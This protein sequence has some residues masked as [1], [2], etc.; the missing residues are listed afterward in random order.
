MRPPSNCWFSRWHWL[1]GRGH[2]KM[3]FHIEAAWRF[4][5]PIGA[6]LPPSLLSWALMGSMAGVME[7]QRSR[8]DYFG[9]HN[10][11]QLKNGSGVFINK[12][13]ELAKE[14]SA[15]VVVVRRWRMLTPGAKALAPICNST[16]VKPIYTSAKYIKKSWM[17]GGAASIIKLN[18]RRT[19]LGW[20]RG[21]AKTRL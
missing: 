14:V 19:W 18:A 16:S 13:E 4:L 15:N 3:R 2:S 10:H 21:S 7:C 12:P 6:Q 17:L 9:R 5:I 20:M 11:V 8:E 1:L